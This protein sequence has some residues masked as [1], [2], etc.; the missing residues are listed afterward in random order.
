MNALLLL[1]EFSEFIWCNKIFLHATTVQTDS[2][3]QLISYK[4]Y[5]EDNNLEKLSLLGQK[6]II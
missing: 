4:Q 5:N 3:S 6:Y 2:L 1:N